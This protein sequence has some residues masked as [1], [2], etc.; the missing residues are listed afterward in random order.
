MKYIKFGKLME[1]CSGECMSRD[2]MR[3]RDITD[4]KVNFLTADFQ[5]SG[6]VLN[7]FSPNFATWEVTF[8]FVFQN[9]EKFI[10]GEKRQKPRISRQIAYKC[11]KF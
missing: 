8:T 6:P 4:Q 1:Y 2:L 7:D 11:Q 3:S 10:F 5:V 9:S